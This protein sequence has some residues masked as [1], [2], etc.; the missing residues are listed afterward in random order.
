MIKFAFF[1][2]PF[3]DSPDRFLFKRFFSRKVA[4]SITR[5]LPPMKIAHLTGIKNHCQE[6]EGWL[7][8]CP[9]TR[10]QIFNSPGEYVSGRLTRAGRLAKRL[11]AEI[12][13]L[14]SYFGSAPYD[15]AAMITGNLGVTAVTC[16]RYTV[17]ASLEAVREAVRI[18]G[19]DIKNTRAAVLGAASLPGALFAF[20]LAGEVGA[21]TLQAGDKK[22]LKELQGKIL[23]QTGLAVKTTK[24]LKKAL[25]GAQLVIVDG[26]TLEIIIDPEDLTPGAVLCDFLPPYKAG[27]QVAGKRKDI[28]IIEGSF[29][30]TPAGE[31]FSFP[32]GFPKGMVRADLA[33]T[34]LLALEG[35]DESLFQG[36]DL[37]IA[38]V[39][40]LSRLAGKCGF[41]MAGPHFCSRALDGETIGSIKQY[42]RRIATGEKNLDKARDSSY[43]G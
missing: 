25:Q 16:F 24:N 9:L 3:L 21:L 15:A 28:L 11:G 8:F 6:T 4:G 37:K 19:R 29:I 38:Q 7:I 20:L 17:A 39:T 31:G 22:I 5:L 41:R 23:Y 35:W 32:A 40:E 42:A 10:T 34:M 14:G 13:G 1:V 36:R 12:L 33:E 27:R 26:N 18:I 43:N 2:L 30:R